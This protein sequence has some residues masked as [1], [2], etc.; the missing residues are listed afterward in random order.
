LAA[1]TKTHRI[2]E[3]L[4]LLPPLVKFSRRAALLCLRTKGKE[5]R[6]KQ[7]VSFISPFLLPTPPGGVKTP[8]VSQFNQ[9]LSQQSASLMVGS[10]SLMVM[11][12]SL[13]VMSASLMVMSALLMVMSALLMVMSAS[14]MVMS[15]SL[16]V[17]SAS[18]MV[19]SASLMVGSA[20]LMVMSASLALAAL[21]QRLV[22]R[23]ITSL[24]DGR[25]RLAPASLIPTSLTPMSGA[26]G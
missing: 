4:V 12:A 21:M 17:M 6:D 15:A 16:M 19:M 25:P 13:M 22:H 24:C 9:I 20:L 8:A 26:S 23:A 1:N 10:A 14:L 7:D 11:S 5:I 18:L 3:L 2:Y